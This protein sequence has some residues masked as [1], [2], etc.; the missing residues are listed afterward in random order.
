MTR[1]VR[2][3]NAITGCRANFVMT[4]GISCY[5]RNYE[6]K[7]IAF[8]GRTSDLGGNTWVDLLPFLHCVQNL[9]AENQG[10]EINNEVWWG[11]HGISSLVDR[12]KDTSNT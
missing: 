4:N 9:S 10:E 11:V 7:L 2:V 1:T 6:A 8:M 3:K 5:C 12:L